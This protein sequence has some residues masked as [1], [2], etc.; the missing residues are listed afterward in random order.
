MCPERTRIQALREIHRILK[1]EGLFL[2]RS[3]NLWS[4]DVVLGY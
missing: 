1:P 3:H 2:F 4:V